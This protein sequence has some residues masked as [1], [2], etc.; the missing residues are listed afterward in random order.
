[1]FGLELEPGFEFDRHEKDDV[2]MGKDVTMHNGVAP[3]DLFHPVVK[4]E[5]RRQTGRK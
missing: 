2:V 4:L 1:M 3:I 5:W